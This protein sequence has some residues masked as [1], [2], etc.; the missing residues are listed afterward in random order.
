MGESSFV[1][2]WVTGKL[3]P[4]LVW[5]LLLASEITALARSSSAMVK[6]GLRDDLAL[7]VARHTLTLAFFLLVLAAYLTR[8]RVVS[9]AQGFRERVLPMLV[10]MAGPV[11]IFVLQK[12]AWPPRFEA[13][14]IAVPLSV[15]GLALSLWSLW[16]LRS[17]FSILAEAR[18]VVRS[19]PYR[20]IRHP[21]YLGEAITML[22]LCL[23]QGTASAMGL[24]AA[25][26]LSQVVRA[27]IEEDKLARE[28]PEYQV[29]RRQTRFILPGIY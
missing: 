24:W 12:L 15:A 25:V 14:R 18:T 29:Y 20:L 11:G 8:L 28:F 6:E 23:L 27:R 13:A 9:R 21:L 1:R 26:N 16:H 4:L 22:G 19:G 2:E 17:S 7:E 3:V 10:F 5:S